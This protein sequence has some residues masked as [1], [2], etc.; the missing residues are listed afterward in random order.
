M[1][2]IG[3]RLRSMLREDSYT[4][5]AKA[6]VYSAGISAGPWLFTVGALGFVALFTPDTLNPA[7]Q[8]LF[9]GTVIYIYALSLVATGIYQM[10]A[11]RYLADGI[12]L[13][14]ADSVLPGYTTLLVLTALTQAP[15]FGLFVSF[16]NVNLAYGIACVGLY[17]VVAGLWVTLTFLS[18]TKD[19]EAITASFA[20][21]CAASVAGAIGLGRTFGLNGC[22]YGFLGGQVLTLALLASRIFREFPAPRA[23]DVGILGAFGK[24]SDLALTGLLYNLGIWVDKLVFAYSDLGVDVAAGLRTYPTYEGAMFLS[25]LTV[26]PA[27]ALFLIRIETSFY[28]AYRGFFAAIAEHRPLSEIRGRREQIAERLRL[29]VVRLLKLQGTITLLAI[30]FA[31]KILD[32]LRFDPIQTLTFRVGA[33]AAFL[34]VL[35]LL[36]LVCLLYFEHRRIV[37]LISLAFCA[38]NAIF[39]AATIQLGPQ[40]HG[41]G[42]GAACL[43]CVIAAWFAFDRAVGELEYDTFTRQPV[44]PK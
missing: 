17:T 11:S 19:Y 6:Y 3:F 41:Y 21:G 44:F 34:Q 39:T 37:L 5:L 15:L 16:M 20:L 29:S 8:A 14:D 36:L 13:K 30:V 25:Y 26:I 9:R 12:W 1:A 42:Y 27:L 33:L 7:E 10:V 32:I 23:F 2:G 35:L 22:A 18:V 4:S 24:Y 28:S 38:L 43:I 40:W 31:P